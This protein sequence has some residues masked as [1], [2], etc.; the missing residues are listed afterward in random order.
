MPGVRVI[1][2]THNVGFAGGCNLGLQDLDDVD[3]VALLNNDAI[4]DRNWLRPLVDTLEANARTRCRV[5]ED[6]VRVP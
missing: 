6:R 4:P 2:H 5:L 3:Y 1:E